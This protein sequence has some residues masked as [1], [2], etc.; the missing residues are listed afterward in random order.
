MLG[1]FVEPQV[2]AQ[3]GCTYPNI[4]GLGFKRDEAGNLLL[5][6]GLPQSSG[7]SQDLGNCSPDF[8]TGFTLGGRYKRLSLSTTWS[9]QQGGKMYHGTNMTLNY[10]GTTKESLPY[11]EGSMIAEGIDEVTGQP[12][13]IEVNKAD[14]YQAY[15]N[16]TESGIYDTSF[17]KLRDLTLTYQ[18]PKLGIFDISIYGFA[19]NVLIW[20]NL[21]NFDPESSQG[22]NNMSGYFERFSVPNTSSFGGGLTINF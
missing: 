21:P 5:L 9:W 19:R 1:G 7:N 4:Y 22:N 16:I 14:Y 11:H 10:F 3:A 13:T 2:R 15:Y 12:N 20:A 17:V 18:L 6:N 8:T